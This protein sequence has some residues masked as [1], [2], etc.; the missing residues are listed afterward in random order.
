MRISPIF[1]ALLCALG[2]VN[3]GLGQVPSL[4]NYQGR[5][6]DANGAP[7]TGSKNFTLSIY[8]G[9]TEGSLLYSEDIGAVTL[10][11]NGVY[12]FQFGGAGT[13]NTQ[14]TETV[15]S[16]NGTA[17][18]FQK[19]F[20]NSPV[21][22]GSVSA[23]DGT[24][25]WDQSV[26]S[27]NEDDFGVA[28]STRLRRLTVNYYNGAPAGGQTITATYRYGSTGITGA[29]SSG[30]EHWLELSLDGTTQAPRTRILAVP[31]AHQ[32]N[33]AYQAH[34]ASSADGALKKQIEA[35]TAGI[36]DLSKITNSKHGITYSQLIQSENVILNIIGLVGYHDY[37]YRGIRTVNFDS[38]GRLIKFSTS[39][40]TV[41]S[42]TG[43]WLKYYYTDDTTHQLTWTGNPENAIKLVVNPFPEKPVV[44]VESYQHLNA[45]NGPDGNASALKV[46]SNENVTA[47]YSVGSSFK[48]VYLTPQFGN[49]SLV[50]LGDIVIN[51]SDGSSSIESPN[52][53]IDAPFGVSI[54]SVQIICQPVP[55]GYTTINGFKLLNN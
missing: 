36:S 51:Y 48:R 8:D 12:S 28:Y 9:E 30:A 24:Y 19:I 40:S 35:L 15:A 25:T 54:T 5:L 33:F 27:S 22:A 38:P 37:T 46:F 20:D 43:G 42:S 53:W 16:T 44:R 21:V 3:H 45:S 34:S 7:V 11:D 10:D 52:Q 49:E 23:T 41:S 50:K 32:T 14:V 17:T 31:F 6:A 18:T 4:I 1:T 55:D 2:F 39:E 26:G 47:T 13:S 29:L